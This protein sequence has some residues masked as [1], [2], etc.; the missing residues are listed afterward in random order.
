MVRGKYLLISLLI[1]AIAML[2][3]CQKQERQVSKDQVKFVIGV[4]QANLVEPWR[5][6]MNEEIREEAAKHSDVRIV[7]TDAVQNSE[8]QVRDVGELLQQGID[9]LIISPNDSVALTPVVAQAYKKIP[10]I[11]LDRAVEGYDYTLYIGPDNKSIGREAGKYIGELLSKTGGNVV[12]IQGPSGVP[13]LQERS[14]GFRE[15]IGKYANISIIDTIVADW[16]RDKAEDKMTELLNQYPKIDVVFAHSDYMALGAYKAAKKKGITGIKFVGIDGFS[17]PNG[18]LQLVENGVLQGTFTCLTGGREAIQYALDI[19]NHEKGLPKKIIPRSNKI[20]LDNVLE[21]VKSTNETKKNNPTSKRRIVL[22]FSQLGAESDWRRANSQ[23]IKTAAHEADIE[24]IFLEGDQRQETQIRDIRSFIAQGVDVIAFSPVIESGWTE[25]L[26][27]AKAAGIPVVLSDRAIKS[28]DASLY[29]SFI[30]SD[31]VE[32]GRRAARWLVG[33]KKDTQQQNIVEIEGTFD[34]APALDRKK[35]FAEIINNYPENTV[36][37]SASGDFTE[38]GG[39]EIMKSALALYGN[40]IDVVYAHNDDMA[41]GAIKAIEEYG[42]RPGKDIL[43]VSVDATE[44]AFKAMLAGKLNCT[45]ECTPLLG[46]QLM[47]AVKTLMTG[48]Q[49]PMRIITSEGVFPSETARKDHVN[50]KY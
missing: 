37:Y 35:G 7:F 25:V 42:L 21:F 40:K 43:I 4:S 8:K 46:P 11:V 6:I 22:G 49:L 47:Q 12:E 39:Q 20:T 18:G 2:G 30:G 27:E 38:A 29:A 32:E 15:V 10:V 14:A 31:F 48:R 41:L 26:E 45:V 19:L 33:Q 9:L 16:Q 17:G 23:S 3:G 44:A 28:D 34:S 36:I 50:R 24:L 5:I 1:L 13:S